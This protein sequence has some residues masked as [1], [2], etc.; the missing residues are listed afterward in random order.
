MFCL[1]AAAAMGTAAAALAAPGPASALAELI[2]DPSLW[3]ARNDTPPATAIES[4]QP[5]VLN[6]NCP[7]ASLP[8]RRVFWD[9]PVAL[10]LEAGRSFRFE[11][12]SPDPA[13]IRRLTVYFR[14][15]QGWYGADAYPAADG[16]WKT[17]R[18][19]TTD[20]R[21]EGRPSGLHAIDRIRLA[22]WRGDAVDT[23]FQVRNFGLDVRP[24]P[25]LILRPD[26]LAETAE[27]GA[28]RAAARRTARILERAGVAASFRSDAALSPA[29][30]TGI[31]LVVLPHNPALPPATLETIADFLRS[32]GRLLGFYQVP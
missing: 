5:P 6:F 8:D 19:S 31:H 1:A 27:A 9:A 7:F 10:D 21:P 11:V 20:L 29:D 17:I 24:A 32:G 14:S 16:D 4:A 22:A 25:V 12:A 18:I 23:S 2:R 28:G 13:P 26:S 3:S 30:L 15:G